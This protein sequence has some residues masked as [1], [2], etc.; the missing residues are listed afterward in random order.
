MNQRGYSLSE[1]AIAL[2]LLVFVGAA[3]IPN[4]R[5]YMVDA[6]LVGVARIFKGTFLRAR[7]RAV[8]TGRQTAIRF[9]QSREGIY[10]C[11]YEDGNYNGVLSADIRTGV[12]HRLEG[13]YRLDGGASG[14]QV[15][16]HPGT[17]AIPP[18]RGI[19]DPADPIRFGRSNMVS[20]SPLGTA[21]PGTY[22][23]AGEGG[24]AAVRVTHTTARVRVMIWRG[25][26]WRER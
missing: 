15:G 1:T 19:L 22:Y 14:V 26:V 7:S 13:P 25:G 24:Q 12:D 8:R 17:P 20:F 5:A 18:A 4:I 23:L 16:I 9:E 2:S 6:E 21:S 3:A 11:L 10:F